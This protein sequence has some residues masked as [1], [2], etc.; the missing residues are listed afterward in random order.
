MGAQVGLCQ[1]WSEIPKTGFLASRLKSHKTAA[2]F[3]VCYKHINQSFSCFV[4]VCG[5]VCIEA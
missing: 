3:S 2:D 4:L 5:F 1:T